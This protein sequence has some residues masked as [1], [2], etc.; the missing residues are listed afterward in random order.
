MI[1]AQ[2]AMLAIRK[3]DQ[4]ELPVATA[5]IPLD[6]RA[7]Q[8]VAKCGYRFICGAAGADIPLIQI[9]IAGVVMG[10]QL[11]MAEQSRIVGTGIFGSNAA[12]NDHPTEPR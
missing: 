3:L 7:F 5:G 12:T 6:V 9:Y 8:L 11:A 2:D 4:G 1:T 10:Y